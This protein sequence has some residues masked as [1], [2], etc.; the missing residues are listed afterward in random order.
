M[1]I[2]MIHGLTVWPKDM[3][4]IKPPVENTALAVITPV[5]EGVCPVIPAIAKKAEEAIKTVTSSVWMACRPTLAA[6][7]AAMEGIILKDYCA[8]RPI[9]WNMCRIPTRHPEDLS[10]T[11]DFHTELYVWGADGRT[12]QN[13]I[14]YCDAK[15]SIVSTALPL[16][17]ALSALAIGH[18][19]AYVMNRNA[20]KEETVEPEAIEALEAPAVEVAEEVKELSEVSAKEDEGIVIAD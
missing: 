16:A 19:F 2:N 3:G 8:E 1:S 5:A 15:D 17:L 11:T 18:L 7:K 14:N 6:A 9:P 4:I 20:E 10:N 13:P 12:C